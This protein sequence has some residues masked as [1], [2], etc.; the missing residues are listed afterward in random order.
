MGV[1]FAHQGSQ[2]DLKTFKGFLIPTVELPALID[3]RCNLI[4]G[5]PTIAVRTQ[6]SFDFL[7]ERRHD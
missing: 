2:S 5:Q 7:V 4:K 3:R 1:V 6:D